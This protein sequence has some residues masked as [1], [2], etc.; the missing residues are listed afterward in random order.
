M[1]CLELHFGWSD[2]FQPRLHAL[3][4]FFGNL[5][6]CQRFVNVCI[7]RN[8]RIQDRASNNIL[9]CLGTTS[10]GWQDPR[11]KNSFMALF[12]STCPSLMSHRW[13]YVQLGN[14]GFRFDSSTVFI[15]ADVSG[16]MSCDGS[17]DARTPFAF[18]L[19]T[20]PPLPTQRKCRAPSWTCCVRLQMPIPRWA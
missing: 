20:L 14:N 3:S 12:R 15:A 6:R 1:E 13:Q 10:R 5:G 7:R 18:F 2:W 4:L 19:P 17:S 16:M 11:L 8:G 9:L